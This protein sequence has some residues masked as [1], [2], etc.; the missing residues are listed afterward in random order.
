MKG[1]RHP[2]TRALY[3]PDGDGNVRV[4][5]DGG[6]GLFTATGRWLAGEVRECDPQLCGWVG[7]VRSSSHRVA[8]QSNAHPAPVLATKHNGNG[9]GNG[10]R[11][12]TGNDHHNGLT[13]ETK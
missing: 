13:G 3:E 9:N 5:A 7:G 8:A 12:A 4:T 6:S 1:V 10:I 2:F 11:S